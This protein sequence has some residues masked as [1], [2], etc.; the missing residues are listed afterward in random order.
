MSSGSDYRRILAAE[1]FH[2]ARR[3]AAVES[4]LARLSGQSAD[5]LSFDQVA[6]TLRVSG[7]SPGGLRQIPIKAIVGSV[8]RYQDFS[9][10]FLPRQEADEDRWVRVSAA[11]PAIGDLPPIE[12]YKIGDNYFVLDGNHRVSIARRQGLTHIDAHVIEVRTRAALPPDAKPDDLIIPAE[13]AAF[14]E[15]TRLDMTRPDVDL[16]VSV[17]GQYRH[18]ESHIEAFR[19]RLETETGQDVPFD[20]AAAR[21]YDEVYLPVVLAM[22]AQG[23]LRYFPGRTE[24]DFFVWLSRHRAELEEAL[25]LNISPEVAVARLAPRV[26]EAERAAA[27]RPSPLRRLTQLVAPD[28]PAPPPTNW[29]AE[30]MVARYADRLFA[31]ILAPVWLCPVAMG[32]EQTAQARALAVLDRALSLSLMEGAQLTVLAALP[33][34]GATSGAAV[35]RLEAR[36]EAER[37]AHGLAARLSTSAGP[38]AAR[39]VQLAFLNDLLVLDRD[40]GRAAGEDAPSAVARDVLSGAQRPL[41]FIGPDAHTQ[42]PRRALLVYD[43]RRKLD[44][45][46]FLAAY[47]AELWHVT[48]VAL[49]ISNGRNTTALAARVSDYLALHE[50]SAAFLAAARASAGLA[51][52]IVAAA[53][54]A[55]ADL[56]ILPCPGAGAGQMHFPRLDDTI[57]A[58]LRHWPG[59]V[60]V[61]S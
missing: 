53:G 43:T 28:R 38:A 39:V 21:W 24:T 52:H 15:A 34:D 61:A 30:R 10:T 46:V 19:Y 37:A 54:E 25:G 22:R 27:P 42:P 2:R 1:Q 60:M 57:H 11:A 48:L 35:A 20:E 36:L 12:V 49:P 33:D 58:T 29:A 6:R 26:R 13:Q 45:A 32:D 56:I 40:Y 14:L 59:A 44:Q 17:P 31:N 8:G 16:R 5:L 7:Q 50:V 3:E 18:L 51:Q 47:V 4:L 55:A 9:R 23:I 41:L